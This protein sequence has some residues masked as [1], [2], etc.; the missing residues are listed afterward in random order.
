[1]KNEY[2]A[3]GLMSG[4]SLDG[5]DVALCKFYY[6]E[7]WKFEILQAET[8]EYDTTWRNRLLQ[9]YESDAPAL[10]QLHAD[11]GKYHG[12]LTDSFI[13]KSGFK[14]DIIASHGHTIF[15]QP[16]NGFTVQIGSAPHIAAATGI[17]VVADFRTSDVALGGQGAPLVPIGDLLLFPEYDYCLN[18]GGIANISCKNASFEK[19]FAYDVCHCNMVLNHLAQFSGMEFDRGGRIA[20]S[21][22]INLT[23]LNTL[24]ALDF[25]NHSPP[26]SLGKEF[27]ESTILPL[28]SIDVRMNDIMSTFVEHIAMQIAIATASPSDSTLLA[29]GGGVFNTFLMERIRTLCHSKLIIPEESI[30]QFK[31]ALIFAFLGVLRLRNEVNCLASV[32]GARKDNIG[33]AIYHA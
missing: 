14:P 31:E 7:Y 6:D 4:T 17:T 28:I 21:G 19:F 24:N 29:T 2:L 30:I 22:Q 18:L 32:T 33:G 8:F 25:F 13:K 11:L 1:M 3:V 12:A 10:A 5:L 16:E 23:L 20:A 9:A 15:H 27:F 26:K